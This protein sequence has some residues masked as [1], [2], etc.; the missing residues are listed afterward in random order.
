M[1]PIARMSDRP[2]LKIEHHDR[3]WTAEWVGGGWHLNASWLSLDVRPHGDGYPITEMKIEYV[4]DPL[5]PIG[6]LKA[7]EALRHKLITEALSHD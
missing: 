7:S 3:T 5:D 4:P 2:D 6:A 1:M